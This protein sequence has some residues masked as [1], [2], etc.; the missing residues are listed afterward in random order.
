MQADHPHA[1][2]VS[3]WIDL[4]LRRR[5][6]PRRIADDEA[7]AAEVKA[8]RWT[9]VSRLPIGIDAAR[10]SQWLTEAGAM[11]DE[12]PHTT[13][14]S[15]AE[16][17]DTIR[18]T[19]PPEHLPIRR[20][21]SEVDGFARQLAHGWLSHP[22]AKRAFLEGWHVAAAQ[23]VEANRRYPDREEV[24]AIRAGAVDIGAMLRG[25]ADAKPATIRITTKAAHAIEAK[26]QRAY[27]AY[28]ARHGLP[29]EAPWMLDLDGIA[30]VGAA[31]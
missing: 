3:A 15:C 14:P 22:N 7:A 11:L 8:L 1:A 10:L 24:A 28:A 19:F 29:D 13:W 26:R 16:V 2:A 31:A 5:S 17:R 23:W 18:A 20:D 12:S 9:V 25:L 4:M 21:E 30:S 27:R 6:T